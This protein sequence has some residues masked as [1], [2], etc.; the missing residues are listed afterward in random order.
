[1]AVEDSVMGLGSLVGLGKRE[2]DIFR[3]GAR[4][5]RA[6]QAAAITPEFSE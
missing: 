1:M 6:L 4:S 5:C 2:Q 3:E